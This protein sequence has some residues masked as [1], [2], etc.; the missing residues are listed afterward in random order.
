MIPKKSD[1]ENLRR[2]HKIY[3]DVYGAFDIEEFS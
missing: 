3:S 1:V 2:L